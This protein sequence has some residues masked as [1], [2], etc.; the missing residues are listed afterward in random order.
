LRW[1]VV[2]GGVPPFVVDIKGE[3]IDIDI[4]DG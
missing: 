3:I 1:S 2:V 4:G